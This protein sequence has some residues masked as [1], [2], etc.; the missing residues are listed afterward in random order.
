MLGKRMGIF[1]GSEN[2]ERKNLNHKSH[3]DENGL[4]ETQFPRERAGIYNMC[5]EWELVASRGRY[6]NSNKNE[7]PKSNG[8][9]NEK[10]QD[11]ASHPSIY[12]HLLNGLTTTYGH[13]T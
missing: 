11:E 6:E 3:L 1:R 12:K 7:Y 13:T 5:A 2:Y 9:N 4:K 8:K 10:V